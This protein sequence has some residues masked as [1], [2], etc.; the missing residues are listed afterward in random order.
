MLHTCVLTVKIHKLK[1]YVHHVETHADNWGQE[2]RSWREENCMEF[3]EK[4]NS[5]INKAKCTNHDVSE[6]LRGLELSV[7]R[8]VPYSYLIAMEKLQLFETRFIDNLHPIWIQWE[9]YSHT[10]ADVEDLCKQYHQAWRIT[11][12]K[13]RDNVWSSTVYLKPCTKRPSM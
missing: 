7:A 4:K 1:K 13:P 3:N 9:W 8:S 11:R 10:E 5:R 2:W 12:G 6:L